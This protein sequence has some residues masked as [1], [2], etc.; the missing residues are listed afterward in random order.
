MV[1]SLLKGQESEEIY[2]T[3]CLKYFIM[4]TI[5]GLT[6]DIGKFFLVLS[7]HNQTV[8]LKIAEL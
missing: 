1:I 8:Q 4:V 3:S 5:N 7:I 6:Q 2:R